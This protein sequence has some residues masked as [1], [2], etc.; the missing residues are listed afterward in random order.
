[1]GE[2][3][4]TT[5]NKHKAPEVVAI[6][7]LIIDFTQ[8]REDA[9]GYPVLAAHPGGAPANYLAAAKKYGAEAAIISKVG[10]DFFGR[11]LVKTMAEADIE[12][13]GIQL[14]SDTFTTL[15]FVTLDE[16]GN[17]D[18]SFARKP[19]ADTCLRREQIDVSLLAGVK[20]LH[21][22]SLS[23]SDEPSHSA[24]KY[25]IEY[26]R[27]RGAIISFDPNIR[28]PLWNDEQHLR[29][30]LMYGFKQADI[31]KLSKEEVEY[32][33]GL[34]PEKGAEILRTKFGVKVVFVTL[35]KD[36]CF[37]SANRYSGLVPAIKTDHVVDTTGAGDIFGG[38]VIAQL[39]PE[40]DSIDDWTEDFVRRACTFACAA[41]TL[42][43]GTLGGISSVP[44]QRQVEQCLHVPNT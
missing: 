34:N 42:S 15:A 19:G 4:Q 2:L 31:V 11:L 1:M 33:F 3:M 38:A 12:T 10:D 37:Y 8:E 26:A 18:F 36:G 43:T 27:S 40:L 17:R 20:V 41:A 23:L 28:I 7:E 24:T 16:T 14:D 5:G 13:R 9:M 6:G 29:E 22:G 35:G 25:A 39:L 30:Q 32:C 44:N 21:F